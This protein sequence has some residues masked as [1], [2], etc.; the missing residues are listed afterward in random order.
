MQIFRIQKPEHTE[1]KTET[2]WCQVS[3]S[4]TMPESRCAL[5]GLHPFWSM[6]IAITTKLAVDNNGWK[7][8]ESK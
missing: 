4:A 2:G 3:A 7:R 8:R 1:I 5:S 6:T